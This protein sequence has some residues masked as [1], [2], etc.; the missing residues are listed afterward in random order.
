[1]T[2]LAGDLREALQKVR[3]AVG[4]RVADR[5]AGASEQERDGRTGRN[6]RK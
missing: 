5:E 6:Q 4:L 3:P 2:G 1:M